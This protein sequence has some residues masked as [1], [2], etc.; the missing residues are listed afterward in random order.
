MM[1]GNNDNFIHVGSLAAK[2][3]KLYHWLIEQ[4][5]CSSNGQIVNNRPWREYPEKQVLLYF[6]SH[7]DLFWTFLK[8]SFKLEVMRKPQQKLVARVLPGTVL[9]T[10]L[11]EEK[12]SS[13]EQRWIK[14]KILFCSWGPWCLFP[15]CVWARNGKNLL[16]IRRAEDGGDPP[17]QGMIPDTGIRDSS[18]VQSTTLTSLLSCRRPGQSCSSHEKKYSHLFQSEELS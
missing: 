2:K 6:S 14:R 15:G 3:K 17:S 11:R 10:S 5:I 9:S 1:W 4:R 7:A 12:G 18:D 16:G 13:R 8:V